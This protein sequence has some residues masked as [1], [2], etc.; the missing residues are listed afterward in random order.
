MKIAN[1]IHRDVTTCSVH[2]QLDHAAKL[3]WDRD[4]GCLPVVD[5]QGQIRGIITDRDLCMAAYTRGAPLQAIPVSEVMSQHVFSCSPAD[6]VHQVERAMSK[7]QIRRIP[8]IDDQGHPI[9][10]VSLNDLARA[11]AIGKVPSVEIAS[12]LA[13]VTAPRPLSKTFT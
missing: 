11:A 10:M 1:L 3:M 12:T 9:G 4:I 2:D 8:V 6:D 13:A 7:H 5:D